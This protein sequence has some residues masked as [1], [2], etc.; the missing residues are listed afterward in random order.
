M[1]YIQKVKL[2]NFKKFSEYEVP[3]T[4]DRNVLIGDN[5]AGKSTILT[6]IELVLSGSIGKVD[7]IGIDA[8]LNANAVSDFLSSEKKIEDLP[9]LY[10]EIYLNDTGNPDL[11]GKNNSDNVNADGLQLICEPNEELSKEIQDVLK[12]EGDN[13]PFEFYVSRFTTFSGDSYSGYRKFL[14]YLSIDSTQINSEYANTQYVKAMYEAIV[15]QPLRYRLKNEYR[16]QKSAFKDNHLKE[17]NDGIDS[18]DFEI[19]S[20]SKFNLETDLTLTEDGIPIEHR[21][22]GKQCFIKTAFAL[23]EREEGKT[24]DVLLLEEPENH[25]S[26]TSMNRLIGQ[27]EKAHNNQVIIAT[28]SSLI[29]S[30]LD[31]RKSILLN[32]SANR[33]AILKDLTDQTAKFFMK[34]PNHNIL[35]L[36]LSKKAILVEGDAEYILMESLYKNVKGTHP[37]DDG[38]HI[39]SVGGTSFKRY[40][41]VSKILNIKTVI[42]RDNDKDYQKNCIDNYAG[43]LNKYIKV[44]ADQNNQRYTFEVCMYQDNKIICDKLFTKG[45]IKLTPQEYMLSNKTTAAFKLLDEKEDE[46]NVPKYIKEAIEWIS[47]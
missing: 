40:M 37:A 15:D 1:A 14:R 10:I 23:R 8:L 6:A 21:G 39:I 27:V 24:I 45:K 7:S 32:S 30:R 41:E 11:N 9:T 46:L 16:K 5:E 42:I 13:F 36:V 31:L 29:S 12:A 22:K 18:Y 19:R 44:Y 35:E 28:H 25:L 26:H 33:P 4:E 20:G 17:L 2:K 3:L 43:Y 38:V 47:K 34:A